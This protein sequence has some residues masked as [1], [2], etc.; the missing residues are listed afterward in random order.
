MAFRATKKPPTK[1]IKCQRLEKFDGA[2]SLIMTGFVA[3][4]FANVFFKFLQA[5][6]EMGVVSQKKKKIRI[7]VSVRKVRKEKL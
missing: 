2:A 1:V 7:W 4:V 6:M 5:M 3:L